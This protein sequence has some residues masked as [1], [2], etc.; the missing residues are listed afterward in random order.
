MPP[1]S[2]VDELLQQAYWPHRALPDLLQGLLCALTAREPLSRGSLRLR[3][4]GLEI[5]A[6]LRPASPGPCMTTTLP[7][8]YASETLGALHGE[9]PWE[10]SEA[11]MGLC[12]DFAL[13]CAYLVKR[14]EVQAWARQRLGQ[15]LLLVGVSAAL[16]RLEVFIEKAAHSPLPVLLKGEFGTEKAL[17]AA[18][19]HGCG[20]HRD[21]PF[22]E[23][24]C[25]D[26]VGQPAQWFE[27]ACGGTLFLNG[28]E[29][30]AHPLQTQLPQFMPSRLGQWL[31]MPDAHETRVIASTTV[32]LRQRVQAGRFSQQLL[33]E[34]DFLSMTIPPLR[35]RPDDI[36]ALL[37]AA[38]E[39]HHCDA[40]QACTEVLTALC[41]RHAWP[42]NLF[43]MER[44]V[45]RLAVMTAGRP[46]Q[47]ADVQH[48]APWLLGTWQPKASC[49][50]L[51]PPQP[52]SS[53][54]WVR[55]VVT[56]NLGELARLHN[57]LR[58][59]LLYLGEHYAEPVSL[60]QLAGQADV[61]PSHLGY[62]FRSVLSMTFKPLLQHIRIEKAKEILSAAPRQRIT[63]VALNV[64]FGDL[65]HFE[66]SFRRIVGRTPTEFRRE[67]VPL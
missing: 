54:H 5:S 7:I 35:E 52:L 19:L 34:L 25:A 65:S 32:D 55:C 41:L 33:A 22:I 42:E 59:A 12:E 49:A 11:A 31:A 28:I 53:A 57:A 47:V 16:H 29:D 23:V 26:P 21:G 60:G 36:Q 20:P 2:Q 38:L 66:K 27:Q 8:T 37:V 40:R 4:A 62:L 10:V 44:T 64:G 61:S 24:H 56:R 58:K 9:W 1:H 48:H 50:A 46:I 6:G 45:A 14:H 15:P 30:L 17:L 3:V 63:E 13:R 51:A 67:A 43:E 39:R 18:S